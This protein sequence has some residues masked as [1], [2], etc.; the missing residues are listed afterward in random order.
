VFFALA[1]IASAYG[2]SSVPSYTATDLGPSNTDLG[3]SNTLDVTLASTGANGT[4]TTQSGQVYAF[5]RTDNLVANPQ[6]LLDTFPPFTNAPVNQAVNFGGPNF[7]YS[8]FDSNNV[9]LNREGVFAATDLVGIDTHAAGSGST[10]FTATRQA[11]GTFGPLSPLWS[12]FNN[13]YS[14]G[15]IAQVL[16]LN[17]AGQLLGVDAGH[18][19]LSSPGDRDY[20]LYNLK[21]GVRTDLA[22]LLPTGW[23]PD[24]PTMALDDQG[25]ILLTAYT[26]PAS[27]GAD[28]PD[29]LFLL[30]PAGL[31]SSPIPAPEPSTFVTL[32]VGGIG[33]AIG[34]RWKCSRS[35]PE[36]RCPLNRRFRSPF[37]SRRIGGFT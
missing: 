33:L 22:S 35:H 26:S 27:P 16:D 11:N 12:T 20:F 4:F 14:G 34:R 15:Q 25:R 28:N 7:A 31:S 21:T 30:T 8:Y 23:Y 32:A 5:P 1:I 9:F 29:H 36:S 37:L 3:P 18:T 17:N 24:I 19:L 2:A 6:S 10:V 13:Y